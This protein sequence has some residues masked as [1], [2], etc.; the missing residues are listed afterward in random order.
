[1]IRHWRISEEEIVVSLER[2]NTMLK[3]IHSDSL[4]HSKS[5][6]FSIAGQNTSKLTI[7]FVN[8]FIAKT[9]I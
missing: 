1:M 5:K 3:A 9:T 2:K 6:I 7:F 4:L 8:V